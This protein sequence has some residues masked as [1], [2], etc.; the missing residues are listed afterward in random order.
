MCGF[1]H[2]IFVTVPVKVTGLFMSYSAEIEWCAH[3]G[4]AIARAASAPMTVVL[5][6]RSLLLIL[7]GIRLP[8]L[9]GAIHDVLQIVLLAR[10]L[11]QH[12]GGR[13]EPPDADV[14]PVLRVGL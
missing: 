11:H 1:V 14:H 4:A 8:Q 6:C 9:D 3:A 13:L 10:V 7:V 2:S 5:M 12:V